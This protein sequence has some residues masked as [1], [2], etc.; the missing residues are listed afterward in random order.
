MKTELTENDI[1]GFLEDQFPSSGREANMG[2]EYGA[3][4]RQ[5]GV[6]TSMLTTVLNEPNSIDRYRRTI[7]AWKDDRKRR[8]TPK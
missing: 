6:L 2:R 3:I 4:S 1:N 5:N 8:L 7:T